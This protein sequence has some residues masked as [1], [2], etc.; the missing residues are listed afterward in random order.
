M[1]VCSDGA[2]SAWQHSITGRDSEEEDKAKGAL[3]ATCQVVTMV[4]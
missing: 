4:L 2:S 1:V 3:H